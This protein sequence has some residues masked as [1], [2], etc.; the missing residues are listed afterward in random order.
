MNS[1]LNNNILKSDGTWWLGGQ[2][3]RFPGSG[4]GTVKSVL[5]IFLPVWLSVTIL[6]AKNRRSFVTHD[7]SAS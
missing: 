3:T 1:A 7:W 4:L 5:G 6:S 2:L